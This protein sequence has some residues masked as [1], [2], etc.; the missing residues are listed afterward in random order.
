ML[1]IRRGCG[2]L[3]V[4]SLRRFADAKLNKIKKSEKIE[5]KLEKNIDILRHISKHNSLRPRLVIGFS[6]ETEKIEKNAIQKLNDKSCDWIIA[7]DVSKKSIGFDTNC[8]EV[9]IYYKNKNKEK[10]NKTKKSI[11]AENIVDR[12]LSEL[13]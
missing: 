3:E 4:G 13:N 10:I 8:N 12:V 5:L 11:I 2:S 9:T 6:A 7:N 1:V